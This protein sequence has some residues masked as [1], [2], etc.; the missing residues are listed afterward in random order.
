MYIMY[1]TGSA[2]FGRDFAVHALASREGSPK[3]GRA[4]PTYRLAV[5]A[6]GNAHNGHSA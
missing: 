5:K 2:N 1:T 6:M 4:L 3:R